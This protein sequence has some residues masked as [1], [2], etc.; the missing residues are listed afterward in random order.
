[1]ILAKLKRG[2]R[3]ADGRA[4]CD[5]VEGFRSYLAAAEANQ[6]KIEEGEGIFSKYLPWAI[7]FELADRWAKVCGD[8]V[9]MGRLPNETPY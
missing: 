7:I 5:Q 1:V 8:P 3:T 6:L 2:Q 4:M 9:A